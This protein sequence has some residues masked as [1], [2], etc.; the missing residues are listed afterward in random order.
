[1]LES[2]KELNGLL[3]QLEQQSRQNPED[4]ELML[5]LARLYVRNGDYG[6][7]ATI[8]QKILKADNDNVAAIVELAGC[9][10]KTSAFI[11]A[12]FYLD[13]ALELK[14][15]FAAAFIT[16]AKLYEA[17]GEVGRQISFMMLAAN[18]A[19]EK[20]EIRL[21]LAE[22]LRRYGDINGAVTQYRQI[23]EVHPELETANFSLGTLLMKKEDLNGA[24][25]CFRQIIAGNP[26]AFD[27]HFNLA[28]C[29]FRQRKYAMAINHFRMAC[30]KTDLQ[31]RAL[32]LTAQCHFKMQDFDHAIVTMEKLVE[33]DERNTSYWKCLAEIYEAAE[34]FDMAVETYRRLTILAAERPEF[35]VKMAEMYLRLEDYARGEKA[36]ETLFRQFP[37]H[38]DGHRLLG[39]LYCARG[40]FK[41][42]IEEYQRTLMLNDRCAE[43]YAGLAGVYRKM[44][45]APEE[46]K[47]LQRAI[48][49]GRESPKILL[50]LGELERKLKLPASL[51]RFRRITE[52]AP[53]SNYAREAEYYIRHKAA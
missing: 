17:T 21:A 13:R 11:D 50:R 5:R 51:D 27:A 24:M 8:F 43:A 42:A 9:L 34:E 4:V 14:P 36:L 12:Q 28:G 38:L 19:P 6:P 31:H 52:L 18:A 44:D 35:L 7:A 37:G 46:Q 39:D 16:Y 53:D 2:P 41:A 20:V 15:G 30:R 33:L 25:Q 10:I 40:H 26:G 48:E 22:Q 1:M 47:A 3:D 32:Y 49:L 45:N 23:L 29:L